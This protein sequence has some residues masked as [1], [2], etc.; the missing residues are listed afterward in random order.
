MEFRT[1]IPSADPAP[2]VTTAT[3]HFRTTFIFLHGN[4]TLRT[5]SITLAYVDSFETLLL[6]F[7]TAYRWMFNSPTLKTNTCP[8]LSTL[9][10]LL[11]SF[12]SFNNPRT[13]RLRT[14]YFF[15]ILTNFQ[16]QSS[17]LIFLES[18]IR[19]NFKNRVFGQLYLAAGASK[20]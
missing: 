12:Q 5:L 9:Y 4:F 16:F 13:I 11:A 2:F 19:K 6:V 10:R 14:K 18:F 8:T 17:L 1:G 3:H 20:F 7:F 15:L